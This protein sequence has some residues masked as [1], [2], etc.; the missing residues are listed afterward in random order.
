MPKLLS[1]AELTG[2]LKREM[3]T[4]MCMTRIYCDDHHEGEPRSGQGMCE[5]CL[6]L[7]NYAHK[8]LEKCPYGDEKPTCHNCPVH[9]YKVSQRERV[10]EIMRYAGPRMT[11]KHPVRALTHLYDKFRRVEHPLK[12]R[13]REAAPPG[14]APG[15]P[16]AGLHRRN[17]PPR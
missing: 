8:R 9:C 7:M 11:L 13:Q 12:L 16:P 2:R 4:L 14:E 10:R 3:Q 17:R 1:M 15:G 6:A 5:E